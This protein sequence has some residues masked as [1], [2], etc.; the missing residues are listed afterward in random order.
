MKKTSLLLATAVVLALASCQPE[1]NSSMTDAQIDS[2]VNARVEEIRMQMMA[3]NDSMIMALAQ[4]R[5]DSII[6]AM[7]GGGSVTTKKTT[8]TTTTVKPTKPVTPTAPV[9]TTPMPTGK[10]DG[11]QG[12]PLGKKSEAQQTEGRPTGKKKGSN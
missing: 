3:S 11:T 2:L 5:A 12:V 7:K 10:N 8:T 1:A 6:A 9:N 4:T